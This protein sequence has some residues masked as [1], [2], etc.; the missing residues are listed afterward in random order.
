MDRDSSGSL[1][2]SVLYALVTAL[3]TTAV[4][5]RVVRG[6]LKL[7][8][9]CVWSLF[10]VF[11]GEPLCFI[12]LP[13]YSGLLLLSIGFLI[14]NSRLCK[15]VE[16]LSVGNRAVLITGCDSG[17]G[18]A[19][20]KYLDRLGFTV[21]A[22]VLNEQGPGSVELKRSGSERLSVL[23]LDVTDTVQI[24]Q[25]YL[26]IKARTKE[27]GLW[28]VV[29]NAGILGFIADGEILPMSLF[30]NCMAVNFFAAVELTQ[31][32][33]PLLR[34]AKGRLVN[35]SSMAGQVPIPRFAAYGASKA[36][37]S[38]FSAVMRLELSKWGVKVATVQPGA[39]KT[40]IYGTQEQWNYHQEQILSHLRPNVKE[41]YGE[42]YILTLQNNLPK[43]SSISSENLQ[44]VLDD[45]LH[46]LIAPNPEH[47]YSPGRSA[48]VI[49]FIHSLL[50]VRLYDIIIC[51]MFESHKHLPGGIQGKPRDKH[52]RT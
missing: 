4:I 30:K 9:W 34:Q 35:I 49:P 31:T 19:L 52:N 12:K 7:G 36:A 8:L 21:F 40:S 37:L 5:L 46:A 45:I 17:F 42:Q 1:Y 3:Y 28:G 41:D 32:F 24:E 10:L 43:M 51:T 20:A 33:L 29:N 50:P 44:P 39:F 22:G 6:E 48:W 23:Q 2:F 27:T 18:H 16:L 15:S 14:S 47:L 25:A 38:I 13:G 11:I 26:E